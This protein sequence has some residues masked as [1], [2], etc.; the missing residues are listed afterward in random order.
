MFLQ[1]SKVPEILEKRALYEASCLTLEE[2]YECLC[3]FPEMTYSSKKFEELL[4]TEFEARLATEVRDTEDVDCFAH[5]MAVLRMLYAQGRGGLL[6]M[7]ADRSSYTLNPN[8]KNDEKTTT[9]SHVLRAFSQWAHD[10]SYRPDTLSNK[11]RRPTSRDL[12]FLQRIAQEAEAAQLV[13]TTQTKFVPLHLHAE[14]DHALQKAR[15]Q[16]G[17]PT[18]TPQAAEQMKINSRQQSTPDP[19]TAKP[20]QTMGRTPNPAKKFVSKC[21]SFVWHNSTSLASSSCSTGVVAQEPDPQRLTNDVGERL[22]DTIRASFSSAAANLGLA[23]GGGLTS[24]TPT[25]ASRTTSNPSTTRSATALCALAIRNFLA[26]K[27]GRQQTHLKKRPIDYRKGRNYWKQDDPLVDSATGERVKKLKKLGSAPAEVQLDPAGCSAPLYPGVEVV[28]G[29][30]RVPSPEQTLAASSVRSIDRNGQSRPELSHFVASSDWNHLAPNDQEKYSKMNY[31]TGGGRRHL[32]QRWW[33]TT[34][35]KLLSSA[36]AGKNANPCEMKITNR[37]NSR[38]MSFDDGNPIPVL[39]R[40]GDL[41]EEQHA[42][43]VQGTNRDENKKSS[44]TFPPSSGGSLLHQEMTSQSESLEQLLDRVAASTASNSAAATVVTPLTSRTTFTGS[45]SSP[46]AAHN[47]LNEQIPTRQELRLD[48]LLASSSTSQERCV[49]VAGRETDLDVAVK[50]QEE[51]SHLHTTGENRYR[52]T[53]DYYE[54][55]GDV[56]VVDEQDEQDQQ[57]SYFDHI[58]A[59]LS[60][61]LNNDPDGVHDLSQENGSTRS[62]RTTTPFRLT[63]AVRERIRNDREHHYHPQVVMLDLHDVEFVDLLEHSFTHSCI[64]VPN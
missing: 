16:V 59:Q 20:M 52:R 33:S 25:P 64:Y 55:K 60:A 42:A 24:N 29:P 56:V 50:R 28:R 58:D 19:L 22:T 39:S 11:N 4:W 49:P 61:F 35:R 18:R 32:R 38:N 5:P 44:T 37:D 46:A 21:K 23:G 30:R 40:D 14:E 34:G 2:I 43:A 41:N 6:N 48:D 7:A 1:S 31:T 53:R 63:S 51:K 12:I 36:A 27:G 3:K 45:R 57:T 9:S 10:A 47:N 26:S 62:L 17:T 13:V 54:S 15:H 8:D